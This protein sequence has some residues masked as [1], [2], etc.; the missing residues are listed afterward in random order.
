M[1]GI[2]VFF[3]SLIPIPF[4]LKKKII[5]ASPPGPREIRAHAQPGAYAADAPPLVDGPLGD[6]ALR[7]DAGDDLVEV[8]LD[9]DAADDHLRQGGVQRLEVEDEV[10]LADVLEH[11]VEGLDVD[12]YQVDEGEGRL[13]RRGYDDEGE[14]RVVAVRHE[15]GHVVLLLRRRVRRPRG[16][17]EGRQREEVA[18]AGRAVRH[19][20]VDLGDEALLDARFLSEGWEEDM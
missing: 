5:V 1:G 15:G 16:G 9:D 4:F 19:E 17:E 20:S 13:G 6:G 12:L 10:E 7:L 3:I 18:R 14:R 2:I 8:R 11:G